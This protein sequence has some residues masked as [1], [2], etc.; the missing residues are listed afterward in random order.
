M[1]NITSSSSSPQ[2]SGNAT[3]FFCHNCKLSFAKVIDPNQINSVKCARCGSDFIEIIP[4]DTTVPQD[5][6][7]AP[8]ES[9]PTRHGI[10]STFLNLPQ[11][12]RSLNNQSGP[13]HVTVRTRQLPGGFT[14]IATDPSGNVRYQV[15]QTSS[16][17]RPEE[18]K[19]E[20][21]ETKANRGLERSNS[22]QGRVLNQNLGTYMNGFLNEVNNMNWNAADN[23]NPYAPNFM[24]GMVFGRAFPQLRLNDFFTESDNIHPANLGINLQ[25][26]GLN[27]ASNFGHNNLL[28]LV[29][30]ISMSDPV[31]NGKPPASKAVLSKLPV[32]SL[33]QK[34]CKKNAQGNIEQP[35][36]AV[37][38]ND[39]KLGEKAQ[40]IPCGHMFHPECIK[41]WFMQ[42]N[43]CPI[44]RYELPTDDPYYEEIRRN[45]IQRHEQESAQHGTH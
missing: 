20:N 35:N 11:V 16:N 37:C 4:D 43:T 24:G 34:H 19:R 33:E 38:C 32:F 10:F 36:C 6:S 41:P 14:Y 12:R 29:Q 13:A 25:D 22:W 9:S 40:L 26:F 27:F 3:R 31:S 23:Q 30:L 39:I 21:E 1:G 18:V 5:Y 17:S 44:C 2:L 8:P 7:Q 42:H 15:Y 45:N 28:D